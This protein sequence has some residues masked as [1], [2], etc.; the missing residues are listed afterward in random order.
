VIDALA[1]L[2]VQQGLDMKL[3][4]TNKYSSFFKAE[5]APG[6]EDMSSALTCPMQ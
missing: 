1:D 6:M 4:E 2:L 5:K 3:E